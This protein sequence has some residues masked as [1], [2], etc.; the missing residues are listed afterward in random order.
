M[1]IASV[2]PSAT[3]I[4]CALGA[5]AELVAR[6]AECDFPAGVEELPVLMRPRTVDRDA[7]SSAIDQRVREARGRNEGLYELDLELLARLRPDV[8]LTQD[9]CGVCSVTEAEVESACARVGVEPRVVSVSPR[10]LEDVWGSVETVGASIGRA[11]RAHALAEDLRRR[12][13]SAGPAKGAR[14]AVVEWLDPPILAGLWTPEIVQRAGGV[15]VGPDP[16]SPGRRTDWN[17][18][19]RWGADVVVL[20]PCSFSVERTMRELEGTPL[21]TEVAR[22]VGD[23]R[24]FVADEAY[25]SRPGPRLADGVELIRRILRPEASSA[26]D[27]M[28]VLTWGPTAGRAS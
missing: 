9:L 22:S 7:P 3:E 17:E 24:T 13:R 2:L 28:P 14:V 12:A 21:G 19:A 11:D 10:S 23:A 16:G 26:P 5:R 20:S 8:L 25:F 27:P 4:V 1:R 6:S 15:A 18:F